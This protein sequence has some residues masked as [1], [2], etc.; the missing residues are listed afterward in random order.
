MD[1]SGQDAPYLALSPAWAS[2]ASSQATP[3]PLT[4]ALLSCLGQNGIQDVLGHAD[5][6]YHFV[7]EAFRPIL[8]RIGESVLV[9]DPAEVDAIGTDANARG[10]DCVALSFAPP[11]RTPLGLRCPTI[12]VFAWEFSTLPDEAWAGDERNDWRCVFART[13]RAI[14][15]SSHTAAVVRAAMGEDYPV[16]AI[17]APVWEQFASVG[18]QMPA[19]PWN[20]GTT[21]RLRGAVLD[22]AALALVPGGTLPEI[23]APPAPEPPPAAAVPDIVPD[24]MSEPAP[25]TVPARR[26]GLRGPLPA[27]HAPVNAQP[28]PIPEPEPLPPPAPPLPEAL[29]AQL[30]L[31]GVVYVSVFNPADGRKN[32]FDLVTAFCWAFR[33]TP[34]ATLVLKMVHT[35][36]A[37]WQGTLLLLL[38]QLSPFRCRVVALDGYLDEAAYAALVGSASYYVNASKC[39]GLCLPLLEFMAAGRPAIAPRHTAMLDYVD[40]SC[41]FVVRSGIEHNVWPHDPRDL[42]R[43]LRHRIEWDSL[44]AA[45]QESYRVAKSAPGG[46]MDRYRAMGRAASERVRAHGSAPVVEQ[47][48]R[49]FLLCPETAA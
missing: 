2:P 13:G 19:R 44:R 39:E 21:L 37:V 36:R 7:R 18:A 11:H 6:S 20:P 32:W 1:G 43:T 40:E 8:G 26:W 30:D 10:R 12:P 34:D 42:F 49:S 33:D 3:R 41:A 28:I 25:L 22:S 5:Y 4:F 47:L 9:A 35:S 31:R 15:L 23:P 38:S 46:A 27:W 48:L 45:Y 16:A 17:P 14:T 24:P 29:D